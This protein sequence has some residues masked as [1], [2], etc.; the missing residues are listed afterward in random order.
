MYWD[1][2]GLSSHTWKELCHTVWKCREFPELPSHP[3]YSFPWDMRMMT[4]IMIIW[5]CM[6]ILK[7]STM[8]LVLA[9]SIMVE[10]TVRGRHAMH[11]NTLCRLIHSH[12]NAYTHCIYVA[13]CKYA[14]YV[15]FT[16]WLD[17]MWTNFTQSLHSIFSYPALKGHTA[18]CTLHTAHS[19]LW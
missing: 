4:L 11:C 5:G 3:P 16:K 12:C 19:K 15:C 8:T 14:V 2:V 17:S 9:T 18:H 13:T 6:M 7:L 1:A 10:M